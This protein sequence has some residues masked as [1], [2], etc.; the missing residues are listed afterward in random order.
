[1][2]GSPGRHP[3]RART[4]VTGNVGFE[5]VAEFHHMLRK[6]TNS[7]ILQ[8]WM[9]WRGSSITCL[10]CLLDCTSLETWGLTLAG[11]GRGRVRVDGEDADH[12]RIQVQGLGPGGGVA[13]VLE[14]GFD[15]VGGI[16]GGTRRG[17]WAAGL[18]GDGDAAAGPQSPVEL[19]ESLG[20]CR[21]E[22]RELTAKMASKGPSRAGGS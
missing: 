3:T 9:L 15:L 1:V 13:G 4:D 17:A 21:P 10:G 6:L 11:C 18:G 14:Q 16:A 20:R 7:L 12:G 19:V 2:E 8:D 22:P 5:S